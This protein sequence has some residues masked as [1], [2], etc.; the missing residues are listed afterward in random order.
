MGRQDE[1]YSTTTIYNRSY[2]GVGVSILLV[3]PIFLFPISRCILTILLFS[4][5]I[6]TGGVSRV[7]S[8]IYFFHFVL[9]AP[10]PLLDVVGNHVLS[11]LYMPIFK[12]I[13]NVQVTF[14]G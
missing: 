4:V 11:L 10:P 3:T 5:I 8:I 14:G 1:K 6:L 12:V 13:K 7:Y 2:V 9:W